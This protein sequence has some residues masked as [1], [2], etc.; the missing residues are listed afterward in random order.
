[1]PHHSVKAAPGRTDNEYLKDRTNTHC[2]SRPARRPH[3]QFGVLNRRTFNSQGRAETGKPLYLH[4]LRKAHSDLA[5]EE[6]GRTFGSRVFHETVSL[7]MA[8]GWWVEDVRGRWRGRLIRFLAYNRRRLARPV[9]EGPGNQVEERHI[10]VRSMICSMR[11]SRDGVDEDYRV[12]PTE[13]LHHPVYSA[14]RF[15]SPGLRVCLAGRVGRTPA[16][17]TAAGAS[18]AGLT[19]RAE[20]T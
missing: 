13:S 16:S 14:V 10:E 5:S 3:A 8:V 19:W 6:P 1:M 12:R 17:T 2:A 15:S 4:I 20:R 9:V 11:I 7:I 18:C